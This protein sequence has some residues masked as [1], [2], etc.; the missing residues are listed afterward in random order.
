MSRLQRLVDDFPYWCETLVSVMGEKGEDLP[1]VLNPVQMRLHAIKQEAMALGYRRAAV[2]KARR[3][4]ITTYSQAEQ[5]HRCWGAENQRCTTLA[6][7]DDATADIF[8]DM[9]IYQYDSLDEDF[10]PTRASKSL[11]SMSFPKMNSM[12]SIRTAG[13]KAPK[14]GGRLNIAHVSEA[15]YVAETAMAQLRA[16]LQKAAR[17][18]F[19]TEETTANGCS[20]GFYDTWQELVDSP[21]T[22]LPKHPGV[23][24]GKN[25]WV[26]VF[27]PW[28]FDGRNVHKVNGEP[29]VADKPRSF[30]V[31]AQCEGETRLIALALKSY[32]M[33]ITPEQLAWR[34]LERADSDQ[35]RLF[36]Q[37]YPET[38]EE[39]FLTSGTCRFEIHEVNL[40]RMACKAP[41]RTEV[42]GEMLI[43]AEPLPGHT[44][45]IAS[46]PSEG[47]QGADTDPAYISVHEDVTFEQVACWNGFR[48]PYEIAELQRQMAI[49]Y[50]RGYV[51]VERNNH[52]H[53]VISAFEHADA[54]LY[55][56]LYRH[57]DDKLGWP[58]TPL[59]R[60][61]MIDE[62]AELVKGAHLAAKIHDP[63]FWRECLTFERQTS[64][65]YEASGSKH[66]DRVMCIAQAAQVFSLMNRNLNPGGWASPDGATPGGFA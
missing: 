27:I 52:G 57:S 58:T 5:L 60:P 61:L 64:G 18:G 54:V 20:G 3:T 24:Y 28:Y 35:R 56:H 14:R 65:K 6:H 26:G 49:Y 13:G 9:A 25:G 46:D 19:Y 33:T 10:R 8:R 63:G 51:S 48:E 22:D 31:P 36:P 50:N 41:I 47:I 1:L 15:A 34:R 42:N 53:A 11:R 59:T 62:L 2:L 23:T 40:G 45:I 38:A 39:A 30:E 66:D 55:D 17:R 44:Y 16:G 21:R 32:G 37:E 12:M 4:G 7:T 43:F 29:I